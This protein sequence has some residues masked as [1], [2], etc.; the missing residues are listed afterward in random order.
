M[1]ENVST[2]EGLESPIF[3]F[4]PNALTIWNLLSHVFENWL[5]QYIE[6]NSS[7]HCGLVTPYSNTCWSTLLQTILNQYLLI[8]LQWRQFEHHGIANHQYL[9]CLLRRTSKLCI[10]ALCEGNPPVTGGFPS[11]KSSNSENEVVWHLS[12][13]NLIGNVTEIYPWYDF[14]N[15]WFKVTDK[16]SQGPMS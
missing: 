4:M 1:T 9:D 6:T 10:T 3:G 5:W 16:I 13:D 14:E 12:W 11:Q 15:Y 8:T 7:T 2:W